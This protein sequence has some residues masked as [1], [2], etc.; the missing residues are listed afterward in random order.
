MAYATA[1]E[2]FDALRITARDRQA[3]ALPLA[4]RCLA[5]AATEID[6]V[7]GR[8]AGDE[9]PTDPPDALAHM[10][11]LARAME[12]YK[13]NDAIFGAVGFDQIGVLRAPDEPFGRHA[14]T[15]I[16]LVQTFGL[17]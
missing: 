12:W 14:A 5:A 15:L 10:V 1:D 9:L 11:N 8:N 16:P 6:H 3:V 13:A 2:L 4:E 7:C 17:A